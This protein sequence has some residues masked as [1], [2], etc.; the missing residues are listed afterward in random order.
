MVL[1]RLNGKPPSE[2]KGVVEMN[3]T[4]MKWLGLPAV[5]LALAVFLPLR[6]AAD[7]DDPPGRV[8]RLSYT[9]GT[10]SFEPAGTDDWV[11]ASVNRPITTGDKLWI[12]KG[13]RAELHLGSAAIRVSGQ[14]GFSFL[15][16]NDNVTQIRLTEGI[17]SVHLREL[18]QD[19]TF[20]IDTPNLAFNLLRAG[21]Y[22]V[23]VDEAGDATIVSV[24][25][26]QGEVTGGGQAFSVRAGQR[27]TFSGVDQLVSE[28]DGIGDSDDFDRWC[29]DR[30]G[31][32][33]RAA[34]AKYVSR[35]VIGY[36]DLD[37]YGEWSQEPDYGPV[38]VPRTVVVGWSPYRYGHWAWIWP[39]GWTWVDDSPW[40]FAPFHYGRW[41]Y[42]RG[43]WGWCPGPMVAVGVIR[44]PVYAPALV[45]WIGGPHVAIGVGFGGGGV[46]WF[47][48]GPREVYVP[49][50]R[51]SRNYVTN[52]N[53]TN[54][55]IN[56]TEVTNVYNNYTSNRVSN[57]RYANRTAVTATS[58]TAFTS[59]QPVSRNVVRVDE[60]EM[61]RAQVVTGAGVVPEQRS[62]LGAGQTA[63]TRPPAA[64]Q[65][66]AVVA[67]TT[68]PAAPVAFAK[69][70]Q[71]IRANGGRPLGRQEVRRLEPRREEAAPVK[72]ERPA[73]K[74]VPVETVARKKPPQ[75]ARPD[76]ISKPE[77][78][79][80]PANQQPPQQP[81]PPMR[82]REDRPPSAQPPPAQ[83]QQ[84]PRIEEK[85]QP[86]R[87]N[88]ER[89]PSAQPPPAQTQQ[90]PRSEEK[91]QP[92]RP[93]KERPPQTSRE[94]Q[95]EQK[96]Q[97][98][99]Q[100]LQ[101][102]QDQKRQQLEKK[103][104][105]DLQKAQKQAENQRQQQEHQKQ[106]G[107][108]EQQRQKL[109]QKQQQQRQKVEKQDAKQRQKQQQKPDQKPDQKPQQDRPPGQ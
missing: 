62:V 74:S 14:T 92:A 30:D 87:P 35:D 20:E 96:Q 69:Q 107:Q 104:Q 46:A 13:G 83:T 52:V 82:Q 48:L 16:L 34:S 89:P 90:P 22:R 19:E 41:A 72:V 38:W 27:V 108:Q 101:Q 67:K 17:V 95:L 73:A 11:D 50:Y 15:E 81:A 43:R 61:R 58:R 99:Q 4:M 10:I 65:T 36:E 29:R 60:R 7:E 71:A 105:D 49:P 12:D 66:R 56:K 2:G 75:A 54:I 23:E 44:R 76:Q 55:V 31:R 64:I 37:D 88:K 70:E 102:Q 93:N 5:V 68:P 42:F 1:V 106:Q 33:E 32:A 24:R 47:P 3:K 80:R 103:H 85:P 26:G 100:R 51:V 59:A 18:D 39:W 45:A 25:N 91:P 28:V 57:I 86:A 53:V 94:A 97:Q 9:H 40:G 63:R 109:E 77:Q 21:D 79:E 8:A 98:E 78:P 6:A 84:P